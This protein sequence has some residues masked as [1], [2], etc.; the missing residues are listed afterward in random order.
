MVE[1][2]VHASSVQPTST[3]SII[4][5]VTAAQTRVR[6]AFNATLQKTKR[7][8][9]RPE[10]QQ[11]PSAETD[12]ERIS[13]ASTTIEDAMTFCAAD[14]ANCSQYANGMSASEYHRMLSQKLGTTILQST[15]SHQLQ[16]KH[17]LKKKHLLF[18]Q[19]CS[20]CFSSFEADN[21]KLI[22]V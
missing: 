11:Q 20:N 12:P 22:E 10:H 4:N 1:S 7:L 9:N 3:R 5:S 18:E 15:L 21:L 6:N 8:V 19:L 13:T 14:E 16:Q 17:F 2:E